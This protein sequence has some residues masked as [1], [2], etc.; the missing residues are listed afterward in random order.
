M[1]GQTK[2]RQQCIS[3]TDIPRQSEA[4]IEYQDVRM[5]R[6]SFRT[7]LVNSHPN[8]SQLELSD[9]ISSSSFSTSLHFR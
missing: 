4:F 5:L 7:T 1:K 8:I 6:M 3:L 2:S 9:R